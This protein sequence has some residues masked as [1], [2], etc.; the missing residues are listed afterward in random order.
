MHSTAVNDTKMRI[1]QLLT[2]DKLS[3]ISDVD[4]SRSPLTS[5]HCGQLKYKIATIQKQHV[6]HKGQA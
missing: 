3:K 1:Q 4:T 5:E 6:S 2:Y